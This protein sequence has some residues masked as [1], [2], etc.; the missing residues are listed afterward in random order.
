MTL[1]RSLLKWLAFLLIGGAAALALLG[2]LPRP[3]PGT[4]PAGD[5]QLEVD[6]TTIRYR[7]AGAG[8]DILL[9][10]G[11]PGSVEDWEAVWERLAAHYRVTAYDRPGH[12]YSG[13]GGRR[14]SLADNA[15]VAHGL[16]AALGL[17]NV[18]FVG[19][20]YGGATALRLAVDNPPEIAAYVLVGARAYGKINVDPIY[21][22]VALPWLGIGFARASGALIAPGVI[23]S[24]IAQSIA[25]NGAMLPAG[26]VEQRVALWSQ[27]KVAVAAALE[28]V[29]LERGLAE[30]AARYHAISKP[31]FIVVGDQVAV[32][33]AAAERLARDIPG[34]RQTVLPETGHYVQYARPAELIQV[35]EAAVHSSQGA[36]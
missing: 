34:A 3:A 33:L 7:Q 29:G 28:R 6:G 14:H 32:P 10:H 18:V 9:A 4:P 12:G 13:S 15:R 20:S 8:G 31:V 21:R 19:H 26:F 22:L 30:L 2:T 36:R 16:I 25:P 1:L 23:R 24:G 11:S 5:R 35:I 27:P 17:R